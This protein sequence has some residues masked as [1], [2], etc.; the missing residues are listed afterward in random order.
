L[1]FPS[2]YG[3]DGIDFP[4]GEKMPSSPRTLLTNG[5]YLRKRFNHP[6]KK[7]PISISGF[8]CPNIDGKVARGGCTYCDNDSFSPNIAQGKTRRY[9]SMD[10][11]D[12][13]MLEAQLSELDFQMK[14]TAKRFTRELGIKHYIAYFQSFSNTYAPLQTLKVLYEKALSYEGVVGISIGTRADCM[15]DEIYEYLAELSTRTELWL[16]FGIQSAY[17]E[18]LERVN[19]GEAYHEIEAAIRKARSLGIKVCGHMIFGLPGETPEMMIEGTR[20]VAELGIEAIKFHPCYIVNNTIMAAQYR[21]GSFIPID[22]STYLHTVAKA[23]EIL[24]AEMVIQ[25]VTAGIDNETLLAPQWC[26]MS[27]NQQMNKVR[28]T[29]QGYGLIY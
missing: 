12:N 21:N 9:L 19:R 11:H 3:K 5:R 27:K 2:P 26:S 22:E 24:P 29:L 20:R 7:I 14:H 25:R 6:V 18:V 23:I 8:T 4:K 17:D 16:E 1:T 28:R 15:N 10:D 13:P